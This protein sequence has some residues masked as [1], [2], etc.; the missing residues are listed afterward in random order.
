MIVA[1]LIALQYYMKRG[2]QGKLR[3][4]ADE[5]GEQFSA[6]ATAYN[7]TTQ[8]MGDQKTLEYTGRDKGGAVK[9]GVSYYEVTANAT[10]RRSGSESVNK[11]LSSEKL[12]DR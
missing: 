1:A 8:Q 2:V 11:T 10:V 4:S 9:R 5:I 12:W 6:N 3:E 7:I